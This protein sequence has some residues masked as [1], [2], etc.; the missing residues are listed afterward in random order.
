M[1]DSTNLLVQQIIVHISDSQTN[2][3]LITV[4]WTGFTSSHNTVEMD[5]QY[6]KELNLNENSFVIASIDL[7][8]SSMPEAAAVELE[9]VDSNDWELTELNAGLI[10]DVFLSQVRCVTLDQLLL[11]KPHVGNLIKF[12]VNSIN[13][14]KE[15]TFSRIGNQTELHIIPKLHKISSQTQD[16]LQQQK[17]KASGSKRSSGS[18]H[19]KLELTVRSQI[20]Y[21]LKGLQIQIN[22]KKQLKGLS[23]VRVNII[24][25]PGTPRSA[26][27]VTAKE[28]EMGLE[29]NSFGSGLIVDLVQL[30]G[31]EE[32]E[33]DMLC[34]LSPLL[35]SILGIESSQGE[36]LLIE[37]PSK[38]NIKLKFTDCDFSV[39]SFVTDSTFKTNS[40]DDKLNKS[41]VLLTFLKS[42]GNQFPLTNSMRLPIIPKILPTGGRLQ[43]SPKSRLNLKRLNPWVEFTLKDKPDFKFTIDELIP[44]SR[45]QNP[46]AESSEIQ[47]IGYDSV[48]DKLMKNVKYFIPTYLYGKSGSGKTLAV[49]KIRQ[50]ATSKGYHVKLLDFD[51]DLRDP[52]FEA[53]EEEKKDSTKSKDRSKVLMTTIDHIFKTS[54]WHSPSLIIL[55]NIDKIVPKKMEQ[56]DSGSSDRISEYFISKYQCAIKTQDNISILLTGKSKDSINQ[57]IFQKH[58]VEDEVNLM[59]PTKDQRGYLLEHIIKTKFPAYCPHDLSFIADVVHET[60]G[61]YPSDFINLTDRVYHDLVSNAESQFT[62]SN[63]TN[64]IAGYT[65]ISLRGVKLQKNSGVRWEDVGGLKEVKDVLIETLEWPTKFAPIFQNCPIRLRSGILLYGYP[66]CGKTMLASSIGSKTGLNFISVKGPEILNKYIGASEQSIRDIFDRAQS[67]KPCILFFDEF[68]SIAPK[69]GH[70][71]TGVTDRIV[72]QLLTQMDGAEGL[73]GVYVIGATSRPDLIDSALLRP[74]RLDKSLI[75]DLPN[76]DDR[77]DIIKTVVQGNGFKLDDEVDLSE[78][79]NKTYGFTGADLQAVMYNGYLK[80]VHEVLDN[81][82][83]NQEIE[84]KDNEKVQ[85]KLLPSVTTTENLRKV[86]QMEFSMIKKINN[87][88]NNQLDNEKETEYIKE[89]PQIHVKQHHLLESLSETN[90]SIS[91]KELLKF[92]KIYHE[93]Q[94]SKR[95]ADM[96]NADDNPTDVGVRS[97]LM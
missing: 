61:Y 58:L 36:K 67:A 51:E 9:P 71:S 66:G 33:D 21:S 73:D 50:L 82:S 30:E 39:V 60:E 63:F 79:A 27:K 29:S 89:G 11:I 32:L 42:Q 86:R 8:A 62:L 52:E 88:L 85:L 91:K 20:D 15:L 48:I 14:G 81:E 59:A 49:Q 12:K 10:E 64:A 40:N 3:H 31:D 25:G 69:R 83:K 6:A 24:P 35:A 74:G 77:L 34:N 92:Q 70:D 46:K 4:G 17:R 7:K 2:Q 68:D 90:P 41:E 80:S 93:F 38:S 23:H 72:N 55:D 26:H 45:L 28:L 57:L 1:L 53:L 96:K 84:A 44:K 37:S 65:P 75:C 19:K 54:I 56:G 5:A 94:Q 18:F 76:Y 95:P 43:I 97:S 87:V 22:S 78:I 16:H 13:S 47:V